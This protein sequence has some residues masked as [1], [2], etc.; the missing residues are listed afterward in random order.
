DLL[1]LG[2]AFV[3]GKQ[4][5]HRGVLGVFSRPMMPKS[6]FLEV[7][8]SPDARSPPAPGRVGAPVA[9]TRRDDARSMPRRS[10]K[11]PRQ[12]ER[13]SPAAETQA[14]QTAI[15]LPQVHPGRTKSHRMPRAASHSDRWRRLK[16]AHPRCP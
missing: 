15:P 1:P 2:F 11:R 13:S 7:P 3:A 4:A 14:A 5:D 12:T 6:G 10:S 16:S 9:A 8:F